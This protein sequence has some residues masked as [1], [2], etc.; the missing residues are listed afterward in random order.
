MTQRPSLVK[1]S[2][3]SNSG[4]AHKLAMLLLLELQVVIWIVLQRQARPEKRRRETKSS[5]L[6]TEFPVLRD[7]IQRDGLERKWSNTQ[8]GTPK[9]SAHLRSATS[10][11]FLPSALPLSDIRKR[12]PPF[13]MPRLDFLII[14]RHHTLQNQQCR[15]LRFQSQK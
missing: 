14:R 3:Y 10:S 7:T 8:T 9:H 11:N 5:W 2:S 4:V 6:M 12:A 15:G 13:E 1:S